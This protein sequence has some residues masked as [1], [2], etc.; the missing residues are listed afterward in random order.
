MTKYKTMKTQKINVPIILS[1]LYIS[2]IAICLQGCKKFD[3]NNLNGPS[4]GKLTTDATL[5]ELNNLVTGTESE[6]REN[7][8]LYIDDCAII[9]REYYRFSNSDPRYTQDLLGGANSILDANGFYTNNSWASRYRCVKNANILL[10]AATNS[11]FANA[12]QKKGYAGFAKTIKAY[13]LLLN[14][15]LTYDNGIRVD[16]NDPDNLGPFVSRAEA[17]STIATLLNEAKADLESDGVEFFF[18]LAPGFAGLNDPAGFL[19]FNRAIYAR[20]ALYRQQWSEALSAVNASFLDLTGS[21]G[22][23][24]Y[25]S[26]SSST[27]DQLNNLYF[28]PNAA[29]EIRVVHPSYAAEIDSADDR[30]GKAPM[31]GDTVSLSDLSSDRD[32]AIYSSN[33]DYVGIIRN[34]ELILIYAEANINAGNPVD[35]VNALNTIRTVH[36]LPAYSGGNSASELID[37]LLKQRRYSLFG[38][39]H[40]WIDMRRYG[41]LGELP[42]DRPGDDVWFMFPIPFAEQ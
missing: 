16:V 3:E 6:M 11:T 36:G 1:M 2:V 34:E 8:Y 15:N 19:K 27:N 22:T 23:G 24:A 26:F 42:I 39:G 32:V 5:E 13:E 35:A 7:Y 33:T 10:T 12:G 28:P 25:M 17:L 29:G 4:L 9:G 37:E 20:V 21:L 41:K 14:L 31:R 30:I 40:R 38:E 18:T